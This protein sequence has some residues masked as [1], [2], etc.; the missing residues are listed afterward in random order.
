MNIG[1]HMCIILVPCFLILAVIFAIMKGNAAKLISGFNCMPKAEQDK[2][3]KARIVK[4]MRN[5]MLK[6]SAVMLAGAAGSYII[7]GYI[8]IAAYIVWLIMFFKNVHIDEQKAFKKYRLK[9]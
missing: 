1:F 9:D 8:A 6:W 3:D 7:S 4:D 5:D 2:Y